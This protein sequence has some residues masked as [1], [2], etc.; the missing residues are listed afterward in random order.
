[1]DAAIPALLFK[2]VMSI[3]NNTFI[4]FVKK[5]EISDSFTK[6]FTLSSTGICN[7]ILQPI[8]PLVAAKRKE[9]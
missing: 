5:T 3:P 2:S 8:G 9:V 1:M 7:N 6:V 4:Y